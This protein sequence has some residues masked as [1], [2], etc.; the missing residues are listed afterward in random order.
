MS[1]LARFR[2][3]ALAVILVASAAGA[4]MAVPAQQPPPSAEP[5]TPPQVFRGGVDFVYVDAYPRRNNQL[6]QGLQAKDF[7]VLEDGK[8]QAI[9]SFEFVATPTGGAA[10]RQDPRNDAEAERWVADPKNRVFIVYI[11]L[12]HISRSSANQLRG[13]MMDFLAHTIGPSDVIALMTPETPVSTLK[14]ARTLNTLSAELERYW[15]WGL[16]DVPA[17]PRTPAE[18]EIAACGDAFSGVDGI[19]RLHR[20]LA[21]FTSL[22]SL[23]TRLS[24]IRDER[25]SVLFLSEG[26]PNTSG[27]IRIG[28]LRG[29]NVESV[30]A[31]RQFGR[32]PVS[33]ARPAVRLSCDLIRLELNNVDYDQRFKQLLRR[34]N[35]GNVT[36]YTID[37]GGLRT[38]SSDAAG[39]PIPGRRNVD[40][41]QE[42]AENTDGFAAINTNDMAR[43]FQRVTDSL[44]GYYLL[45]YA[46]TNSKHDGQYRRITVRLREPGVQVTARRGYLAA[47]N[48]EAPRDPH[49]VVPP[50][51]VPAP[52]AAA[53]GRLARLDRDA[54]M[55]VSGD[56]SG[57]SLEI[58]AEL[59]PREALKWSEG[60]GLRV[61]V[62]DASGAKSRTDARLPAGSRSV[63]I[64]VPREANSPGPWQ[65]FVGAS[66]TSSNLG[67]R[68][69]IEAPGTTLLRPAQYFR[70]GPNPRAPMQRAAAMLFQRGERAHVEWP[71]AKP[72]GQHAVRI[73]DR[74]GQPLS[75]GAAFSDTISAD[76]S[77]LIAD[78][79][80]AVMAE[81]DY[82]LE[83]TAS[84]GAESEMA[85]LAFRVTR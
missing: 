46:S 29:G 39:S 41:L 17:V 55:S 50:A 44:S 21:L 70:G 48:A 14:F 10:D 81:G 8:P 31:E 63:V 62:V 9:E 3:W 71:V 23:I 47:T 60:L 77:R 49:A 24:A 2:A 78:V 59:S 82:I 20:Q 61:D 65:V 80:L 25:I 30:R 79:N 33:D 34:A 22:E 45:G 76:G 72:L 53:V 69:E 40:T 35:A 1:P 12:Y 28:S 56:A 26:W 54:P 32:P 13:P 37:V 42:L 73:L 64:S 85:L 75:L 5:A 68:T 74:R 27:G 19:L 58:V 38:Y 84:A 11:D 66:E 15:A 83:A 51:P 4:S 67:E 7:E 57:A 6:V 16:L 52:M 43:A 18:N 36:F